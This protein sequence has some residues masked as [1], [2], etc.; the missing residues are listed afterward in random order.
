M[1]GMAV[2]AGAQFAGSRTGESLGV[3]AIIAHA[4]ALST[5]GIERLSEGLAR[6][7]LPTDYRSL[8]GAR[9]SFGGVDDL[10][11]NRVG[12]VAPLE[13]DDVVKFGDGHQHEDSVDDIVGSGGASVDAGFA[14]GR[15]DIDGDR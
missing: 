13:V 15:S 14:V 5:A 6:T 7:A 4:G 9:F 3:L 2:T 10:E 8:R 12:A 11:S 1:C